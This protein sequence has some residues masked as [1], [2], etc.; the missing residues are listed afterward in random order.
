MK[1]QGFSMIEL[2]IV[3]VILGVLA[4]IAI[5]KIVAPNEMIISSEGQHLL[6]VLLS[7]QKRYQL[8]NGTYAVIIGNLDV[9]ETPKYFNRVTALDGSDANGAVASM[10][11]VGGTYTLSISGVDPNT[12]IIYCAGDGCAGARCT[13]G[14][15]GNQCNL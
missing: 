10:S 2:I 8:E 9:T 13:L 5:P 1:K 3:V 14:G 7:A 12:G 11:R 4:A 6:T 15:G